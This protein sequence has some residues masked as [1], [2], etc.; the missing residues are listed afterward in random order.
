MGWGWV[1]GVR[2][3]KLSWCILSVA[4]SRL[5][6]AGVVAQLLRQGHCDMLVLQG[7]WR[8]TMMLRAGRCAAAAEAEG[9]ITCCKG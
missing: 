8:G 9:T 3:G 4:T 5:G 2:Y 1:A 7:L 6:L